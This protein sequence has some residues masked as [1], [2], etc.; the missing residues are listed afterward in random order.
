MIVM[1]H[2]MYYMA[3][4]MWDRY[5]PYRKPN[6]FREDYRLLYEILRK[7]VNKDF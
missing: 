1:A 7:R 2:L 4:S 5:G 3:Y 6:R